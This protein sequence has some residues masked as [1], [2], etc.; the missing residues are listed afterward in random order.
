MSRRWARHPADRYPSSPGTVGVTWLAVSAPRPICQSLSVAVLVASLGAC[1]PFEAVQD[2]C[3]ALRFH[4]ERFVEVPGSPELDG[5]SQMTLEAFVQLQAPGGEV[6][7]VSHHDYGQQLGYVLTIYDTAVVFRTYAN[8]GESFT[9]DGSVELSRWYHL[10]VAYDD[11]GARVYINGVLSGS[12]DMNGA[13]PAPF[14]GPLR[15][16]AAAGGGFYVQGMID[17]VRLSR[18]A[19][20]GNDF[21]VPSEP[22]A[23]DPDTVALWYF[24]EAEG[25]IVEDATGNHSGTL[26]QSEAVQPD[27]PERFEGICISQIAASTGH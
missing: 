8:G 20:Y 1:A 7:V 18:V 13:L 25:Q 5:M 22:F 27:D 15:I 14:S 24:D 3:R 12:G 2:G 10:A 16:G 4:D 26:G 21:A 23:M 17:E 19:R 6:Q 11:L 9:G